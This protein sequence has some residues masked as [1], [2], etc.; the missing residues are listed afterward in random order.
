MPPGV[1]R[2]NVEA[3]LLEQMA[4]QISLRPEKEALLERAKS[5][6]QLAVLGAVLATCDEHWLETAKPRAERLALDVS[7]PLDDIPARLA[8]ADSLKPS[9]RSV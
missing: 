2:Y 4:A 3:E 5:L 8:S 6:R 7:R 9:K 1:D